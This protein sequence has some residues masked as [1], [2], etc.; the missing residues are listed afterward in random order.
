MKQKILNALSETIFEC[1][2]MKKKY[3][4]INWTNKINKY[5]ENDNN[6]N[7]GTGEIKKQFERSEKKKKIKSNW[8]I[9]HHQTSEDKRKK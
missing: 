5:D 2:T 1:Q 6:N 3:K 7:D 9:G 8:N 4:Y